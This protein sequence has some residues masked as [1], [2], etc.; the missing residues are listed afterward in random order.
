MRTRKLADVGVY[1]VGA[2]FGMAPKLFLSAFE[3]AW[4]P[5]FLSVMHEKDARRIVQHGLHVRDARARAA[6]GGS[7][8]RGAGSAA[9][10]D[11]DAVSSRVRR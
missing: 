5:F 2:S 3:S 11:H 8:G 7:R 9:P 10:H 1:S 6:G 4:T